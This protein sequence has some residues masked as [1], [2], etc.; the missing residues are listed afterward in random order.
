M[1]PTKSDDHLYPC[2]CCGFLMFTEPPGCFEI[3]VICNW[4]DDPVQLTH[5]LLAGGA[6]H[7]NLWD[8]Q[9]KI[10]PEFPPQVISHQ[11]HVRAE[12]WRPLTDAD[13]TDHT[14]PRGMFK[15]YWEDKP[16][17]LPGP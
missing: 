16:R 5:P 2:P 12:N 1:E 10:L 17:S 6:N 14:A 8:S 15:Y 7:G 3:C 9:Q 4:E 13:I 11:H